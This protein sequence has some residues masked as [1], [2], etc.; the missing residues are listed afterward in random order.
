MFL[1]H[2]EPLSYIFSS[3]NGARFPNPL[4]RPTSIRFNFILNPTRFLIRSIRRA[5]ST[6]KSPQSFFSETELLI[7]SDLLRNPP[8][9][10]ISFGA[11]WLQ[12]IPLRFE[13]WLI[14]HRVSDF[15]SRKPYRTHG[16]VLYSPLLSLLESNA[17]HCEKRWKAV[18][19]MFILTRAAHDEE[20]KMASVTLVCYAIQHV[21]ERL[22]KIARMPP[23]IGH[24]NQLLHSSLSARVYVWVCLKISIRASRDEWT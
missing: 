12:N 14:N 21:H 19:T 16:R 17:M 6:S 20:A 7:H 11:S 4:E 8:R 3:H 24:C 15:S 22:S 10:L 1:F 9:P 18:G 5:P 23:R 2:A 13:N